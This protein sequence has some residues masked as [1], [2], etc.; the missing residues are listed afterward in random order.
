MVVN[1]PLKVWIEEL[2]DQ[3]IDKYERD[4]VEGK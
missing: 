1:R 2:A 4:W 3:Y